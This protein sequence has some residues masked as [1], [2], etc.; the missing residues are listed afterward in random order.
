MA[1][2]LTN[3]AVFTASNM[4]PAADE[5]ITADWGQK[6]AENTMYTYANPIAAPSLGLNMTLNS[7]ASTP[8]DAMG[9]VW[10]NKPTYCGTLNGTVV[11]SRNTSASPGT[12]TVSVWVDGTNVTPAGAAG[13]LA[14]SGQQTVTFTFNKSISHLTNNSPYTFSMFLENS[15]LNTGINLQA[16]VGCQTF[17]SP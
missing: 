3:A 10:F 17:F 8:L 5:V 2:S 13:T 7:N 15:S 6:I 14:A 12:Q 16:H 9:T 11:F 4:K 1:S